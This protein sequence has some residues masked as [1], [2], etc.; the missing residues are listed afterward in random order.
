MVLRAQFAAPLDQ[1]DAACAAELQA[2]WDHAGL[3]VEA[4]TDRTTY[5][6]TAVRREG[7]YRRFV[8]D[9]VTGV[10]D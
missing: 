9:L 6:I 4:I 3:A 1:H 5:S 10:E 7:G 8:K 2:R